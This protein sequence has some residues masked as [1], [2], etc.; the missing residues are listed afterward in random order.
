MLDAN[1]FLAKIVN[2][3]LERKVASL[4]YSSNYLIFDDTQMSNL[5]IIKERCLKQ[6]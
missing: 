5:I 3:F 1:T 2:V 4:S 6:S